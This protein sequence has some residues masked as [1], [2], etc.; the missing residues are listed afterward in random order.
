M[1]CLVTGAT[2]FIGRELCEQLRQLDC[3]LIPLSRY[4]GQLVS[5][6]SSLAVDLSITP[7][8]SAM[9][10]GVDVV[11]HL[12]GIAHTQASESAYSAVNHHATTALAAAA[13]AAGVRRFVFLSSVKAM[14]AA[15]DAQARDE[16]ACVEPLDPYGRS[17]ILAENALRDSYS[18]SAMSVVI[19]RPPLVYGPGVRGN[20]GMLQR[21]VSI[22][23]PRPPPGGLRS[24]IGRA[25]LVTVLIECGTV[26]LTGVRTW[27]VTDGERYSLRRSFDALA[28]AVGRAPV[29]AWLPAWCWRL[30]AQAYDIARGRNS[31]GTDGTLH[32]LFGDE[33]YD[34]SA[35][36]AATDWRPQQTL[37]EG[38]SL[39]TAPSTEPAELSQ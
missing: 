10:P 29:R 22:G 27:I 37:E 33:C 17:K 31:S 4:G 20:L 12:A 24:M 21:A 36:L 13:A 30:A 11:F 39:T 7:V 15:D 8:D 14:G 35:I 9:F 38:M 2:G 28:A 3:D 18:D 19:L 16:T 25:D 32:K 1:K 5:G 6:T 23:L 34:C 26:S